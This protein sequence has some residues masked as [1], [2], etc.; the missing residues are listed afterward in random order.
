MK[1]IDYFIG[2][3][4]G[5]NGGIVVLNNHHYVVD[6]CVMPVLGKTKKEYDGQSIHTIL[7]KYKDNSFAILEKAKPQRNNGVVQAFKTG[8]G[9]GILEMALISLEISFEII[10]P[11]LWQKEIFKG[12]DMSDTKSASILFCKRKWPSEDWT[13]TKKCI[14]CHDGLTDAACIAYYGIKKHE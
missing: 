9:A 7:K 13:A 2:I 6:R 10:L 12:L 4:P 5:V 3:D 1:Q 14:K 11:S 8:Y